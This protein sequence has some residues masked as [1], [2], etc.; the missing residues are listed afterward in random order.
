MIGQLLLYF[1]GNSQAVYSYFPVSIMQWLLHAI[2]GRDAC[3]AW[4]STP[5]AMLVQMQ[6]EVVATAPTAHL[7]IL[8][9]S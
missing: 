5:P 1:P 7:A 2:G 3:D 9:A 6:T 4:H 8:P